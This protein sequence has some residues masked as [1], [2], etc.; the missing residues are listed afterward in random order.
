MFARVSQYEA[1]SEQLEA[2]VAG[3]EAATAALE[4]MEGIERAYLL[5]N[6][7]HGKAL[8]ITVWDSEEAMSSS[9]E[10]AKQ[11]RSQTIAAAQGKVLAVDSYEVAVQ[12]DFRH[13]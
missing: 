9:A 12:R 5:V 1:P 4:Q 8:T 3:F 11:L 6:R 2:A 13:G 7:E 10:K